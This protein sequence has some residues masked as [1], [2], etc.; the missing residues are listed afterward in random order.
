[1]DTTTYVAMSQQLVLQRDLDVTAN[2]LANMNTTAFKVETLMMQTDPVDLPSKGGGPPLVNFV[3]DG[4]VARD[5]SA[6]S[7]KETN[8]PFDLAI[9]GDGFFVVNTAAGPRYTRDGRFS[10]N[11]QGQLVTRNGDPVQGDGGPITIDPTKGPVH[12]AGD[13]TVSQSTITGAQTI[14]K[15]SVVSFASLSSLSKEGNGLYNN[16]SNLQPQP[17]T[18]ATLHQGVLESSNV[19]PMSQMIHLVRV[20]SAYTTVSEMLVNVSNLSKAAVDRL[21]RIS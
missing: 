13:G 20:T 3:L 10:L 9:Q 21:G 19:E 7:M 2:N 1:M 6:G 18:T 14:G 11:D 8:G 15:V 5:F 12:V 17:S 16:V 4:G